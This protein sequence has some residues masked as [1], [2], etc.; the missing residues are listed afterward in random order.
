MV[1]TVFGYMSCSLYLASRVSQIYKNWQRKNTEGLAIS[2][3]MCAISANVCYG[4]AIIIRSYTHADYMAS[5]PWLVGSLGTVC[6]DVTIFMQV[7][8]IERG[9]H[10]T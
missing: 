10:Q 6:L 9:L 2:M 3:F 5:L 4:G 8:Q 1:G 7:G